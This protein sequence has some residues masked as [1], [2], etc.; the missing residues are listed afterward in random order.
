MI[1][2][3]NISILSFNFNIETF[4]ESMEIPKPY[5]IYNGQ[6]GTSVY[7]L[8][9]GFNQYC[10]RLDGKAQGKLLNHV[11]EIHWLDSRGNH[12]KIDVMKQL[13]KKMLE[14]R[15]VV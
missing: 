14:V 8:G 3:L 12:A 1:Y 6:D 10:Y 9:A 7:A 11:M 5:E 4:S 13:R 2:K 15:T